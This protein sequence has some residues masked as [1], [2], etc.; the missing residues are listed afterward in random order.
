VSGRHRHLLLHDRGPLHDVAPQCK[1]VATVLFVFAVVSTPK[2]QVWA[3]ALDAAL[4]AGV[5]RFGRVPF[6]VVA[7]RLVIELPFVAFAFLLPIV[8]DGPRVDVFGVGL[9]RAGLWAA[10]NILAKGTIGVAATI[11][12]AATTPVP[13]ILSGLER[14]R[15]PRTLV[16]IMSFMIRYGDVLHTEM[17]R[18]RIARASRGDDPRWIWQAK[19]LAQTSGALFVR[20]YERGE[21]IFVAMQARGF[22]G[23]M[24][25]ADHSHPAGWWPRCLALPTIAALVSLAAW[26]WQ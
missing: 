12:L 7:R 16:A 21:R 18:M 8:G 25:P 26:S 3:F 9:S 20:S 24:P 10:F 4:V 13:E 14:L 11:V 6:M 2:E 15:V 19:A 23:A 1:L 22:D 17:Q 5:A